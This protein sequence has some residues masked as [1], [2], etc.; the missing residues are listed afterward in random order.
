MDYGK[1][2]QNE[3]NIFWN[4]ETWITYIMNHYE[5]FFL[6]IFVFIIIYIV[7]HISNINSM[8]YSTGQIIPLATNNSN[9]KNKVSLKKNKV[10]K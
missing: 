1:L 8:I 7:D 4:I 5:K 10:K 9:V 6:L 2:N 3:N